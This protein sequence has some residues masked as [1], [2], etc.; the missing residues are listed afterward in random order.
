MK[1]I[2]LIGNPIVVWGTSSCVVLWGLAA[3][4]AL[5]FRV[6]IQYRHK[7]VRC[8]QMCR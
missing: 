4:L 8:M 5:H 1:T 6:S 2:Y 3:A 7:F